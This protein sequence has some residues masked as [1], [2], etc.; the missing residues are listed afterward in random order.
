MNG[1]SLSIYPKAMGQDEAQESAAPEQ[2]VQ[3][4]APA[5]AN[6]MRSFGLS[7][8]PF[9]PVPL[10]GEKAV[11]GYLRLGVYATASYLTWGKSRRLSYLFAGAAGVSLAT[12]LAGGAWNKEA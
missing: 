4:P 9:T 6:P 8:I 12:S 11:Y 3:A 2:P 10:T 7:M 1:K 5:R